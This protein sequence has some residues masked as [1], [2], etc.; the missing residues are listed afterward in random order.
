MSASGL[1]PFSRPDVT[2]DEQLAAELKT[3]AGIA[4]SS[5]Q[6]VRDFQQIMDKL[7]ALPERSK[8]KNRLHS[9]RGCQFCAAPCRYGYFSLLVEPD[10]TRLEELLKNEAEKTGRMAKSRFS[11]LVVLRWNRSKTVYR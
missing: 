2:P 7:A 1:C 5:V 9:K 11:G 10:L 4:D 8:M 6:A 3:A